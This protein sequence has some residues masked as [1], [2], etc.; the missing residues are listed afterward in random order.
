MLRKTLFNILNHDVKLYARQGGELF[1]VLGFSVVALALFP[2][3]FGAENPL[4]ATYAPAFIW[5]IALLAS[6]LSIPAIL[7]RDGL[8][9]SLDQLRL[10]AISMEWLALGK[11][12]ANWIGCQL[13]LVMISPAL[14]MM[15]G[16]SSEQGAR[17]AATMLIGTPILSLV[18]TLGSALTLQAQ[19][20]AGI[21]ALLVLPLYIPALIFASL[22]AMSDPTASLWHI[23]EVMILCGLTMLSIPICGLFSAILIRMQD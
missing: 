11:A 16:L 9:G 5:I 17:L 19:N 7:Q 4:L 22:G 20:R 18:G 21:L 10:S 3:A 23:D 2:L 15:L 8:D 6:L 13:P 1:S 12:L 14:A